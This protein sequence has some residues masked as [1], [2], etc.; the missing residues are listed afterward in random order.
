MLKT[1]NAASAT[2]KPLSNSVAHHMKV[3][4]VLLILL[5][6]GCNF[7]E[8]VKEHIAEAMQDANQTL[9]SE[10]NRNKLQFEKRYEL[11]IASASDSNTVVQI[12]KLLTGVNSTAIYID[13]IIF[14]LNELHQEDSTST[15][16]VRNLL[17]EKHFADSVFTKY[18][19]SLVVAEN[20]STIDSI[21]TR[22]HKSVIAPEDFHFELDTPRM[23]KWVMQGLIIQL[24]ELSYKS[25]EGYDRA[26]S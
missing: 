10:T 16:S 6:A 25:L 9:E 21:K 22:I 13:S 7:Q 4:S 11:A 5:F 15:F 26:T 17:V 2:C 19:S 23:A 1:A 8:N 12:K 3:Y 14:Q 24:Y 20:L 18:N